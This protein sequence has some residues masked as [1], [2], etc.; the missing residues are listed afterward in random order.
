VDDAL[1]VCFANGAGDVSDDFQPPFHRQVSV[2]QA[3]AQFPPLDQFHDEEQES[4][5]GL[6]E[7][8]DGSDVTVIERCGQTR[9]A[10]ESRAEFLVVARL[11][12]EFYGDSPRQTGVFGEINGAHR[13]F[14][15][16]LQNVVVR[17][18]SVDHRH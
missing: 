17:N 18:D 1:A 12:G 14:A 2:P 7:I 4:V 13:A 6:A 3:F 5:F 10:L 9:F 15:E 11:V 16:F 8:I